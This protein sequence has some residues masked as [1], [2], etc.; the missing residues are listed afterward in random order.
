MT[1]K[2][3]VYNASKFI[4]RFSEMLEND[5]GTIIFA[6]DELK[7]LEEILVDYIAFKII[8]EVNDK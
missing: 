6:K 8:D 7:N 2:N 4:K 5:Q 3:K 1:S